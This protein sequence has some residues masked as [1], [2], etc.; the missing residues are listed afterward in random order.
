MRLRTDSDHRRNDSQPE[1]PAVTDDDLD[2]AATALAK[3]LNRLVATLPTSD[4][5]YVR[6]AELDMVR[7]Q[8]R[9]FTGYWCWVCGHAIYSDQH[10]TAN[11][12]RTRRY[13]QACI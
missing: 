8:R 11:I 10:R 4:P 13:H 1:T 7:S 2:T 3:R 12:E 5:S 6:E 9:S